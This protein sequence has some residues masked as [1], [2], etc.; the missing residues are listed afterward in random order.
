MVS[1]SCPNFY[2]IVS[3]NFQKSTVEAPTV[4]EEAQEKPDAATSSA[5]RRSS[6]IRDRGNGEPD[7]QQRSTDELQA[8]DNERP[9]KRARNGK[10]TGKS[11]A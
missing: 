9:V 6:R 7:T 3:L 10:K 11:A 4:A 2:S 8:S 5:V 1:I